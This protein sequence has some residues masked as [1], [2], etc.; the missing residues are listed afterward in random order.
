MKEKWREINKKKERGRKDE[1]E[2]GRRGRRGIKKKNE[3][4]AECEER[5]ERDK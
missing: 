5:E 4:R 1:S 2:I 3:G